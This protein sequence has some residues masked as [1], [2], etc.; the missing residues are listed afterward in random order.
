MIKSLTIE[1]AL[2]LDPQMEA[3]TIELIYK[4]RNL[5]ASDIEQEDFNPTRL[6]GFG[7]FSSCTL[8]QAAKRIM[9]HYGPEEGLEK[10]GFCAYCIHHAVPEY[11]LTAEISVIE[12][13]THGTRICTTD[14]TYQDICEAQEEENPQEMV[15]S[16]RERA[17]FLENLL[18]L[19]TKHREEVLHG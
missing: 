8:C 6:T 2:P 17:D 10:K 15:L 4:Y 11:P 9:Q 12:A 13:E 5:S 3:V 16:F 19:A 1:H 14:K 7:C 18:K